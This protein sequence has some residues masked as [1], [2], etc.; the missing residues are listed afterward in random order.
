MPWS[1]KQAQLQTSS[2]QTED[3]PRQQLTVVVEDRAAPQAVA[4]AA[5][6]KGHMVQGAAV[7]YNAGQ[8]Q[9]SSTAADIET[10]KAHYTPNSALAATAA[11]NSAQV[12]GTFSAAMQAL[13]QA[14]MKLMPTSAP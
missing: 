10:S 12:S 14:A 11:A 13:Q 7:T 2:L 6:H 9:P 5:A 3:A 4:A 1:K 8:A